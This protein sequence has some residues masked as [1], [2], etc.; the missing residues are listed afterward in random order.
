MIEAVLIPK[1]IRNDTAVFLSTNQ[2]KRR[3]ES[4]TVYIVI[5]VVVVVVIV[6]FLLE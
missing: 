1:N 4:E 6:F 2:T 5:I 3:V